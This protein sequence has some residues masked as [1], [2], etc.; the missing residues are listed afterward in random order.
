MY[1]KENK[2]AHFRPHLMDGVTGLKSDRARIPVRSRASRRLHFDRLGVNHGKPSVPKQK[3][4]FYFQKY[5][6]QCETVA[7]AL[8]KI[9]PVVTL[10]HS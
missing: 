6:V 10:K 8:A 2:I 4:C 9:I 5:V 3:D 1:Q 7:R